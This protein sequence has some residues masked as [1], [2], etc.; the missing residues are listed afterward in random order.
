MGLVNYLSLFIPKL[1][2]WSSS[3]TLAFEKIKS[4]V[5]SE[6]LLTYY[7]KNSPVTLQ[8]D[9]TGKCLD[10]ALMQDR[11]PIAFA[12]KALAPTATRYANIEG[13]LLAVMYECEKFHTSLRS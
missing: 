3:H 8:V 12:L 1:F 10:T 13:E 5:T 6:T 11:G 4:I 7:D 9:A 2:N